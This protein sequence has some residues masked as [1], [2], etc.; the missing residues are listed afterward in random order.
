MFGWNVMSFLTLCGIAQAKAVCA[1]VDRGGRSYSNAALCRFLC[2]ATR[3][4]HPQIG[5]HIKIWVVFLNAGVA[6]EQLAPT[7]PVLDLGASGSRM[8]LE[9]RAAAFRDGLDISQCTRVRSMPLADRIRD[10]CGNFS[11]DV[12]FWVFMT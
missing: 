7:G 12:P 8:P 1:E 11:R 5:D 3:G 10:A 6:A 9:F 4:R 2:Q